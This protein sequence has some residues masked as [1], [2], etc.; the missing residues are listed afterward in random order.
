MSGPQ[1]PPR[2]IPR[3]ALGL[4]V[5]G[6]GVSTYLTVVHFVSSIP[7]VCPA[8]GGINCEK[9]T[10]SPWSHVFGIPVAVLGTVF[11]LTMILLNLPVAWR[12]D[13]GYLFA[14]RIG[15]ACLGMGSVFYLVWA[16]L[17][18]IH[19][20]CLWCTS[21]HVITFALFVMIVLAGSGR[22]LEAEEIPD[23]DRSGAG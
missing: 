14:V 15:W 20:I 18:R 6:L 16:E 5:A 17:F 23:S 11:Y 10:N 19:A 8:T 4:S 21:V 13:S 3:T 2:W 12:P 9:V 1:P 7:L 22:D